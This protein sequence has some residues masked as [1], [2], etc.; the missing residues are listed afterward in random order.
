MLCTGVVI[1]ESVLQAD[2]LGAVLTVVGVD[3]R[4]ALLAA[5]HRALGLLV[6]LL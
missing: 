2:P 4:Q 3:E 5:V 6:D 1:G